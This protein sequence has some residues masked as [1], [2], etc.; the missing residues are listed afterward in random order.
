MAFPLHRAT[1]GFR[2]GIPEWERNSTMRK[3]HFS[4]LVLAALTTGRLASA[5]GLAD[6]VGNWTNVDAGT[7]G[8]TRLVIGASTI[9]AWG[10]CHPT[11]CDWGSV[12]AYAYASDVGDTLRSEA[13]SMTAVFV[14]SFSVSTVV[15]KPVGVGLLSADIFTRF[16]DGS[17][18]T[19][20]EQ[21]Y[22][23]KRH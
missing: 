11:D 12:P 7:R 19:N 1:G 5:A 10:Q 13:K 18:R 4:L 14:K 9:R 16:T 6:L 15:V 20:Y 21:I 3:F 8:V 22:R 17:G 2:E 23:M